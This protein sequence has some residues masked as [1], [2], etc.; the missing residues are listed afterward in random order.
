[1]S[2]PSVMTLAL[3]MGLSTTGCITGMYYEKQALEGDVEAVETLSTYNGEWWRGQRS[4]HDIMRSDSTPLEARQKAVE[5]TTLDSEG[6]FALTW[7]ACNPASPE[8]LRLQA[9]KRL[10]EKPDNKYLTKF[11]SSGELALYDGQWHYI[12]FNDETGGFLL[13]HLSNLDMLA[14]IVTARKYDSYSR[15]Y[16]GACFLTDKAIQE[17]LA[18]RTDKE[19]LK[20]IKKVIEKDN[21]RPRAVAANLKDETVIA[22]YI[23]LCGGNGYA[24]NWDVATKITSQTLLGKL[25]TNPKV[26]QI[27]RG[28]LLTKLTAQEPVIALA[29]DETATPVLRRAAVLKIEDA[30]TKSEL[31]KTVFNL[32]CDKYITIDER[33]EE[34]P[35]KNEYMMA[36]I[37][38]IQDEDFLCLAGFEFHSADD[39][40]Y[41]GLD[42]EVWALVSPEAWARNIKEKRFDHDLEILFALSKVTDLALF[43]SIVD[44]TS[45]SERVRNEAGNKLCNQ[46]AIRKEVADLPKDVLA[47]EAAEVE[48]RGKKVAEAANMFVINGLYLGMPVRDYYVL[49][50]ARNVGMDI[51]CYWDNED[52]IARID[53]LTIKRGNVYAATGIEPNDMYGHLRFGSDLASFRS[54][55][56]TSE[57]AVWVFEQRMWGQHAVEDTWQASST[58]AKNLYLRIC[59]RGNEEG[60]IDLETIEGRPNKPDY[61]KKTTGNTDPAAAS[62]ALKLLGKAAQGAA[63]VEAD[64]QEFQKAKEEADEALR[65][66]EAMPE[67]PEM[68]SF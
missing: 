12:K 20:L 11:L 6:L 58:R 22:A 51:H 15:K 52:K 24:I 66:L 10:E 57:H 43:Q 68:P 65:Q 33:G 47:K 62:D 13:K 31:A 40:R 29:K 8:T 61:S 2:K 19:L 49:S 36:L 3:L 1:M 5:L 34:I 14:Q 21:Y 16:D 64:I 9:L 18:G 46:E 60:R 39:Y 55:K 7:V 30:A 48:A 4:L 17:S 23:V 44:D 45:Y 67:M 54:A 27:L 35:N 41:K 38:A 28:R 59:I 37:R 32:I 25:V 53:E 63:E 50:Y 56:T 26:N 42:D